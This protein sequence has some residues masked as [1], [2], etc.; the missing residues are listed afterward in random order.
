MS[1]ADARN[2]YVAYERF[3]KQTERIGTFLDVGRKI[4]MTSESE[5][6][7]LKP[8]CVTYICACVDFYWRVCAVC[9]CTIAVLCG[10]RVEPSLNW[11]SIACFRCMGAGMDA[12]LA[13]PV[14]A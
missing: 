3:I 6:P 2:G 4:D 14:L 11:C 1:L 5:I 8:V 9:A 10:L 7:S 13:V 12:W